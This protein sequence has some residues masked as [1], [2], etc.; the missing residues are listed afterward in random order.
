M[1][2]PGRFLLTEVILCSSEHIGIIRHFTAHVKNLLFMQKSA[3][4]PAFIQ[5]FSAFTETV[6]LGHCRKMPLKISWLRIGA[7]PRAGLE[8]EDRISMKTKKMLSD[9]MMEVSEGKIRTEWQG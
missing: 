7:N 6:M 4:L 1:Y 3:D 2:L 5:S 9:R 8:Y